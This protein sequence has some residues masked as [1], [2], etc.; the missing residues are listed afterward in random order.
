MPEA[1]NLPLGELRS[2][3]ATRVI[4]GDRQQPIFLYCRVG[5]RSY[6]AYRILRQSGYTN[7]ATLAGGSKTFMSFN[8]T[9]L[10]TGRPGIPFIAHE[11]E[12]M[13]TKPGALQ[14]A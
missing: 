8:R 7:V 5:F 3:L 4:N 9:P 6:L 13:A 2:E 12:Q 11:E 10:A 14:H 1:I